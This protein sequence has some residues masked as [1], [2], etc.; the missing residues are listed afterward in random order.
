MRWPTRVFSTA[1]FTRVTGEKIESIG[2]DA[3]RL[4]GMLVLVAGGE[5][6]ADLD[7]EFGFKLGLLVE[8]ADE[9]VLVEDFALRGAP[10]C[11]RR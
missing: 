4:V 1:Y 3:D 5:A 2:D 11:R 6:A 8:R 7:F 9:L 10:R